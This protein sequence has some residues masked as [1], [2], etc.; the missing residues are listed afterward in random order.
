MGSDLAPNARRLGLRVITKRRWCELRDEYKA[1]IKTCQSRVDDQLRRSAKPITFTEGTIVRYHGADPACTKTDLAALFGAFG[2]VQYVDN[3]HGRLA[4][5]VRYAQPNDA[6]RCVAYFAQHPRM[7]HTARLAGDLAPE[8]EVHGPVNGQPA[9]TTEVPPEE[10]VEAGRA[11]I[12]TKVL[13]GKEEIN[14]WHGVRQLWQNQARQT[15]GTSDGVGSQQ[16]D[17]EAD[18][19]SSGPTATAAVNRQ[20]TRF[21]EP[22]D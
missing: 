14:Y 16:G 12:R 2:D 17:S 7:V 19:Q 21:E 8:G 18:L 3:S 4:G 9:Q 6:A 11:F 13:Q 22:E 5:Y 15:D 1:N 20:H 10:S